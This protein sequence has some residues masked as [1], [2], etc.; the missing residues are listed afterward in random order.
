MTVTDKGKVDFAYTEQGEAVLCISDHLA[1]NDDTLLTHWN[2]LQDKIKAYMGFIESE[3]YKGLFD[4]PGLKPCIKI[5]FS[6][7]WPPIVEKYLEKL[8]RIC[9]DY[10]CGLIWVFDPKNSPDHH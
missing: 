4:D 8:K 5:L 3:Q 1:W 10:D 9:A 2:T 6:H 7:Q